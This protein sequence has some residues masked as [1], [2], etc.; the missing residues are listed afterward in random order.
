MDKAVVGKMF[1]LTKPII[2]VCIYQINE[3]IT[4]LARYITP[5]N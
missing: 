3:Q 2:V 5:L 4:S 1:I